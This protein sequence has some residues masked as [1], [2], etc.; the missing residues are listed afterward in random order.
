MKILFVH[1]NMP[2]QFKHLAPVLVRA[3]HEV[4]FITKRT[5]TTIEGI[6]H[7][8]YQPT[9]SAHA[10]TH[11]YLRLF[12][13][14]VLHGQQ[15]VRKCQD[16]LSEGFVP[17]LIVAHPGWGESLFIKEM[18]ARSPL[19]S[20]CEFFY[21]S[22]G[23]DVGFDPDDP[24]TLDTVCRTRARNAHL[25]L[26]LDAADHG[27]SPTEWQRSRHPAVYQ[28]K[29]RTIF[30]GID[31]QVVKPDANAS[32]ALPD[33]RVLTR[34]D[35]VITYV[36]RNLEPYRGFPT[37]IRALPG[38]LRRRPRAR[39]V[40]VGGDEVSYGAPPKGGGTWREAMLAEVPLP[41]ERVHFVGKLPYRT[42]LSLLQVSSVHVYLTYP[43]VLSWSFM[44]AMAA[45]C[46]I[47]GSRTAPVAE[48]LRHGENGLFTD[49]FD[50]GRVA[51]DIE[52]ALEHPDRSRLKK[53]ARETILD[54]YDLA[55][56]LP[57]QLGFLEEA[58]GRPIVP[59]QPAR[60]SAR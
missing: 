12:E 33:G 39:I 1:Q 28:P 59:R 2:G 22:R 40:I 52:A 53:A 23:A 3:G 13:N 27:W 18:F 56:C 26:S 31:T 57:K 6:R 51:T 10:S 20:Y 48:V 43:F 34:S 50:H 32:F 47:V 21:S 41:L 15:V 45:E 54:H 46:L 8:A 9:R 37:F 7:I 11:H 16:L 4:A 29:I 5:D 35:E 44:E 49:F 14:S 42:Y 60:S 19:V 58:C 38:V 55:T 36:A 24:P 30:D 17:D 25:I